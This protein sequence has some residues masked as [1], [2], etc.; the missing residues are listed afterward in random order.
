MRTLVLMARVRDV[1]SQ[2]L[3]LSTKQRAR[4]AHELI[5]SLEDG[6]P[7][8]PATVEEA[9]GKEIARRVD[10]FRSGKAKAI[11]W[12]TSQRNAERALRAV[13]ARKRRA[14]SQGR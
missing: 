7:D 5:R 1:L 6:P 13:R 4:V 2:A 3:D 9:W 11:P 12:E 10:D 14:P 8:D